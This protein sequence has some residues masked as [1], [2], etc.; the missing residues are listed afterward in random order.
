MVKSKFLHA[1][2]QASILALAKANKTYNEISKLVSRSY[3]S[4]RRV[5]MRGRVKVAA[6]NRGYQSK[7]STSAKR[8]LVRQARTGRF[9]A[10]K[11]RDEY[12]PFLTF[13]RVQQLLQNVPDLRWARSVG[14][15]TLSP[16]HRRC[17]QDWCR[18]HL[19]RGASFWRWVI[20]SDEKR[21]SLDGPD[22]L[23][24]YWHDKRVPKR[25]H[26]TRQSEGGSVVVW[27]AVSVHG[28]SEL[29]FIN[30]HINGQSY[31]QM[32]GKTLVPFVETHSRCVVFQQDRAPAHVAGYT[33]N[34]LEQHDI[35]V[36]DW[37]SRSPDLNPIENIW[38]ELTK[39]VYG[40]G[41]QYDHY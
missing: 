15:P 31:C 21:C 5:V 26:S 35:S 29:A 1:E 34:W 9:T 27:G 3:S 20:F 25:W 33:Q 11:L 18:N 28:K 14:I 41:K 32:L 17:H 40:D 8:L 6:S 30:G 19:K 24:S 13:R 23:K 22:G 16:N 37:P 12:A 2:E 39:E 7:S 10:R 4:V 36:L 38:S